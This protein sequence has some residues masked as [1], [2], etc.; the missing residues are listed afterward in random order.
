MDNPHH[1]IF[2]ESEN[3]NGK[4]Y[5][6]WSHKITTIRKFR[7]HDQIILGKENRPE[8]DPKDYAKRHT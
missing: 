5:S 2:S 8:N 7:D 3:L 4:N 6:F 1:L